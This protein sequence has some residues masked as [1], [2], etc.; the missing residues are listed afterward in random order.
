MLAV[1]QNDRV[2][3]EDSTGTAR[4]V[5]LQGQVATTPQSNKTE[6]DKA[7]SGQN[8]IKLIQDIGP[9]VLLVL[10]IALVVIGIMLV[11]RQRDEEEP[12]Y[13]QDPVGS[14]A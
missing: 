13:D 12:V 11:V 5:A 14:A 3:L 10:G 7:R 1:S 6:V 9:L 8:S 2:A 4:L